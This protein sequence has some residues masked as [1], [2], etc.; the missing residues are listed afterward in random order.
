MV[1]NQFNSL[2]VSEKYR[3]LDIIRWE[4][5]DLSKLDFI[6][7]SISNDLEKQN[8]FIWDLTDEKLATLVF[9]E[10]KDNNVY[11]ESAT[12]SCSLKNFPNNI[13]Y[14]ELPSNTSYLN[15][16]Y[17]EEVITSS[18][19][20]FCDTE[21]WYYYSYSHVWA[22]TLLSRQMITNSTLWFWWVLSTR[23]AGAWRLSLVIW[24]IRATAFMQTDI[25]LHQN[26]VL[27]N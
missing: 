19:E 24:A 14:G 7:K 12:S 25:S 23:P 27:W 9:N 6:V 16:F 4:K 17:F 5:K 10:V 15:A 22:T 21:L 8:I 2:S 20:I 18:D 26:I 3:V 1:M 13:Y 11:T